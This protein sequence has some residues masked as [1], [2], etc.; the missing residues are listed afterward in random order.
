M[1]NSNENPKNQRAIFS[2]KS[3]ASLIF[4]LVPYCLEIGAPLTLMWLFGRLFM[5]IIV[6]CSVTVLIYIL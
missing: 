4:L 5:D 3:A 6:V 2:Q 1:K